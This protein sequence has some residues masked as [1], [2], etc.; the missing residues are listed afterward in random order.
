MS[1][2]NIRVASVF[3]LATIALRVAN[4]DDSDEHTAVVKKTP[5]KGY[6]VKSEK[7]P[8]WSGGCYPTKAKAE[9]RLD[10]VEMFKHM[11]GKK[12]KKK[13]SSD[14]YPPGALE[15][16]EEMVEH[17]CPKGH[18]WEVPMITELGGLFYP[19]EYEEKGPICPVCGEMDIEAAKL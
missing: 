1:R 14:Y 13:S 15:I 19:S 3:R 11:K 18:T 7:N 5:G 16:G 9:K 12:K 10:E 8:D 17:K 4:I 2:D 6:C